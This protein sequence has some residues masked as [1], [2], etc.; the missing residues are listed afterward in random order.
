MR[1]HLHE[2]IQLWDSQTLQKEGN[3]RNAAQFY[4]YCPTVQRIYSLQAESSVL[5]FWYSSLLFQMKNVPN[6]SIWIIWIFIS[7][8]KEYLN[9]L[10]S[11]P[12]RHVHVSALSGAAT[13]ELNVQFHWSSEWVKIKCKKILGAIYDLTSCLIGRDWFYYHSNCMWDKPV[14]M[15][16]LQTPKTTTSLIG[17]QFDKTNVSQET[18][19]TKTLLVC[20]VKGQIFLWKHRGRSEFEESK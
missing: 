7:G 15:S 19:R 20:H 3:G 18:C 10:H 8:W 9:F 2:Y 13:K 16:E 17:H 6:K 12:E 1:S 4:F 14:K 11:I 5:P